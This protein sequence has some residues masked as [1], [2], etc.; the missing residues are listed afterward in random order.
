MDKCTLIHISKWLAEYSVPPRLNWGLHYTMNHNYHIEKYYNASF[1]F[2]NEFSERN[3]DQS[4]L[5]SSLERAPPSIFLCCNLLNSEKTWWPQPGS[6][7]GE[8]RKM[9]L[10]NKVT[11]RLFRYNNNS[12]RTIWRENMHGYLSAYIFRNAN[13]FPRATLEKNSELR[14]GKNNWWIIRS[15]YRQRWL[16]IS[17]LLPT[18]SVETVLQR[19]LSM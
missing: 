2:F 8:G 1:V 11:L 3:E 17:Y 4:P 18:K 7:L 16:T 13:I 10:G 15:G 5:S 12:I 14:G 6:I 19:S 9:A